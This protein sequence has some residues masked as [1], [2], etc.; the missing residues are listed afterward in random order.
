[1]IQLTQQQ[2]EAIE[3]SS[4]KPARALDPATNAEYVLVPADVY[5]RLQTILCD[6]SWTPDAY[7]AA[8][9]VFARDGWDDPRMDVYD[10][11]ATG[12]PL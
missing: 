6:D 7:A 1:M 12:E 3:E 10:S 4:V 9:E 8:M 5:D 2:H 11:L